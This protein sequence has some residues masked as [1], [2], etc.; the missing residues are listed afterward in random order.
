[1]VTRDV[2]EE[3]DNEESSSSQQENPLDIMINESR[4]DC[5]S[6]EDVL[7]KLKQKRLQTRKRE[8]NNLGLTSDES[9]VA[10]SID[11][12]RNSN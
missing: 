5:N 8:V 2:I 11:Q 7:R 6:L 9:R 12:A 10:A 4:Q 1:M 3:E